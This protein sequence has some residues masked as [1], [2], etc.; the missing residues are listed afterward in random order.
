M[1]WVNNID[2][3]Y[4]G[5]QALWDVSINVKDGEAVA[6]VGSNG[7]GKSSIVKTISGLLS[8]T[9]GNITFDGMRLDGQPAHKIVELGVCMVPEGRRLFPDMTTFENLEMGAFP[10]RGREAKADSLSLVYELFPVLRERANQLARTLSG[11]EQQILAICRAL[12]SKPKLLILDEVS[13]GLAPLIIQNLSKTIKQLN[14]V[15]GLVILLVEQNIRMA[16]Q[17]ASRGYI[18]ENG[19]IVQEGEIDVLL[20]SRAVM[21]AY[22]GIGRD[23]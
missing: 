8:P 16:L 20:G 12:M 22:L 2:V 5:L 6:L 9:K 10:R 7:A 1:L 13:Q 3:N 23:K 18:L 15:K 11:G 17:L 19:R 4:G 21:D 14:E